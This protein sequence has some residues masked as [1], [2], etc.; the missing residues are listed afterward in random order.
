MLWAG[1]NAVG[2]VLR[3]E[4]G[5][6]QSEAT[7]DDAAL[8]R[9]QGIA[10][11]VCRREAAEHRDR[12][13]ADGEDG[14]TLTR[15]VGEAL[16]QLDELR[17]AERSPRRTAIEDDQR[18]PP[19]PRRMQIDGFAGLVRQHEVRESLP[20]RRADVGKVERGGRH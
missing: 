3:R 16:L 11:A 10:D 19:G 18:P 12:I 17:L 4:V 20:D 2:A 1:A 6:E 8:I 14:D 7:N 15:E 5:V 9:E 13:V